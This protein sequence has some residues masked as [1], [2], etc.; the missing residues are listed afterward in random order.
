[1]SIC[2]IVGNPITDPWNTLPGTVK[3][4]AKVTC[5]DKVY[6]K[7]LQSVRVGQ[8]DNSDVNLKQFI[9]IF[10]DL[11]IEQDVI[12]FGSHIVIPTA[13]Q[14]QLLQELHQ[15]HMSAVKM[16]ETS[17]DFWWPKITS[18]IDLI[19]KQCLGCAK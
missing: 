12:F 13:L 14:D 2:S 7:L 3:D 18:Q 10:Q 8:L 17:R 9:S 16:K 4:V 19:C 1:M 6:G 5:E 15:T 11:H